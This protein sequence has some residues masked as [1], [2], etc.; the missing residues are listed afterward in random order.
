V[1]EEVVFGFFFPRCDDLFGGIVIRFD[2][3]SQRLTEYL[4]DL[5]DACLFEALLE[6]T[7]DRFACDTLE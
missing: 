2:H 1:T 6:L 7:A 3:G 5:S 4:G